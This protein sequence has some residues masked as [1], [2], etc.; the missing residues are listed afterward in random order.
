VPNKKLEFDENLIGSIDCSYG[1][2]AVYDIS[3]SIETE[4]PEF[5]SLEYQP[6]RI[7]QLK[8]ENILISSP[9]G[10]LLGLYDTNYN[11]I[12]KI[13]KINSEKVKPWGLACD[14]K[15]NVYVLNDI[16]KTIYKLDAELKY[17]K[18]MKPHHN[19]YFY[20]IYIHV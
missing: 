10:S 8:D 3:R 7:L 1:N 14:S 9:Y 2:S 16:N 15:G 6:H 11:L 18:S 17:V 12:R 4:I 5:I 13:D 19:S 20:D